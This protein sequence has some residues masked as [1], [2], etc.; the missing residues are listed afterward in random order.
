MA[1][2]AYIN[3][4]ARFLPGKPISN[5]EMETYLGFVGGDFK[6]KSKPIV[7]RNN[8]I[9]SRHYAL[10]PEGKSTHSNA[11]MV[12]E[13]VK[14]L[15]NGG[16][17]LKEIDLLACGTSSPDQLMPSHASMVHG[18]LGQLPVEA[19]S[20]MGGCCAGIFAL[21]YGAMAV[22]TGVAKNAVVT[23][24]EKMSH[25]MQ[26]RNFKE[27][28]EKIRQLENN[29]MLGFEKDFLRWMLSDGAAAVLVQP[30]PNPNGL[31]LKIEYIEAVSFANE[32]ETCM[33]AGGDKSD[34]GQL[35]GWL[36]FDQ[37]EWLGRSIFSVKQ[38]TRLLE[39][40]IIQLGTQT[41]V[42]AF[43]KHGVN[44]KEIDW[45]LPHISSEYF[46]SKLDDQMQASGIGIPQ[47]K[48]FL[49][50]TRVGNV[51]SASIMLALEEM[52]RTNM[53]KKDQKIAL[54]IPESARF[55]YT[56]M[57]LTVC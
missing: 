20:F 10:T 44:H 32:V 41:I 40:H 54:I 53:L 7:L 12:A 15:E 38:D 22:Q 25:W 48:W 18:E 8:K 46:R 13:A 50:L 56:N 16:F 30:T 31:S 14:S 52:M 17:N 19:V 36:T 34:D 24:S 1:N 45:F 23:G 37:S 5:E 28:A 35:H 47:E 55:T 6:S 42:D 29:P 9:T 43:R 33:Y 4:I 2:S 57:M 26:A 27:E 39:K 21:R 3:L 49:N 51:G 11:Q